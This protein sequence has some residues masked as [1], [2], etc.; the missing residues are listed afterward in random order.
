MEKEV[1]PKSK[2]DIK[3]SQKFITALSIVSI[4]GFAAIVSETLFS[5]DIS[6]YAEALLMLVIGAGLVFEVKLDHLKTISKGL[7][8]ENFTDLTTLIIGLVA[9]IAAIFSFPAIRIDNPSFQ[10]IK[11]II[12]IIA[13][14]IIFLQ[15]WIIDTHKER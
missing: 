5:R 11:G 1:L 6:A 7:S 14:V 15:T 10:A 13:I 8:R 2:R 12:S 9:V 3:V 4:V